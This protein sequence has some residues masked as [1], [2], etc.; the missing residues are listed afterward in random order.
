MIHR[1]KEIIINKIAQK[2]SKKYL[3]IFRKMLTNWFP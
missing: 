1:I 2:N 3:K